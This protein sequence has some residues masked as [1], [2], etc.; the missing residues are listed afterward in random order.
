MIIRK[1]GVEAATT[2]VGVRPNPFSFAES[3]TD[4]LIK[5]HWL[6]VA[7]PLLAIYGHRHYSGSKGVPSMR[8]DLWREV[9]GL[10]AYVQ[11]PRVTPTPQGFV[12]LGQ[13]GHDVLAC[14]PRNDQQK[15]SPPFI[16]SRSRMKKNEATGKFE[17]GVECSFRRD[18]G[19]AVRKSQ[20]F[21]SGM[22]SSGAFDAANLEPFVDAMQ[23]YTAMQLVNR[24]EVEEAEDSVQFGCV[25]ARFPLPAKPT[26]KEN[27]QNLLPDQRQAWWKLAQETA[28]II[29]THNCKIMSTDFMPS[30]GCYHVTFEI[31]ATDNGDGDDLIDTIT[32]PACGEVFV[33]PGQVVAVGEHI[34]S[35]V[36]QGLLDLYSNTPEAGLAVVQ[37]QLG[38]REFEGLVNTACSRFD[39]IEGEFLFRPTYL[40]HPTTVK[41]CLGLYERVLLD[42][43]GKPMIQVVKSRKD[44][45][46]APTGQSALAEDAFD[47]RYLLADSAI[48]SW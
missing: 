5:R 22:V 36:H 16:Y 12:E 23:L 4:P 44:V 33:T 2:N 45:A 37:R 18:F 13:I 17:V 6:E 9:R 7:Q 29:A 35:M 3:S 28:P 26:T 11:R 47:I 20:M 8:Q 32:V 10:A 25:Y 30:A 34:G 24:E 41:R 43:E 42:E 21:G 1:T 40:C 27:M 15:D 31:G 48:M 14:A 39:V 19:K 46:G 38:E